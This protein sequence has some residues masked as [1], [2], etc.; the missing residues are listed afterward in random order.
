[1][2][3]TASGRPA[4]GL[5]RKWLIV[6]AGVLLMLLLTGGALFLSRLHWSS[7]LHT[8]PS[9][10]GSDRAASLQYQSVTGN[11]L[12]SGTIMLG[13][14]VETYAN[15]NYNQPFSEMGT[16]G[17]YDARVGVLE[18]PVTTNADSYQ[19]EVDN[20]VFNCQPQW[21][22]TL[23]KYFPIINI[24][25]DHLYDQGPAGLTETVNRLQ[26]AGFQTVG[27]Y[28]PHAD[29]DDCK[30]VILPVRLQK[31]NG[32]QVNGSLP[33][34][35]C[36][37]NY[38][39]IFSP[40]PAEIESIKQW[41]RIMPV[42]A[43][44]NG[45]PEYEHIAGPAQVSDAH[46]M[47][48]EGADF[49]IGNG[50]HWAQNT[51]VYKGKLI[52]Y[53]M[54]NFIFDQLDTDGRLALNVSVNMNLPYNDNVSKWL[55]VGGACKLNPAGCLGVV[56]AQKLKK[57]DPTFT[58]DA[59]ASYGGYLQV[60]HRANAQQQNYIDIRTNWAKTRRQLASQH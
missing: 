3:Y 36:S 20:L 17:K 53:S 45:G 5:H 23:K 4:R 7:F 21:L 14:A 30:P 43:L 2:K 10:S 40:A 55:Q 34:A 16:L 32:Q 51:E 25:S 18:C 39:I 24:S 58:F 33:V 56:D 37:F 28:N 47:I 42:V 19:N 6:G 44:M 11:Y 59:I 38:K 29:K 26:A 35:F 57:V 12:F 1:M 50:T 9:R 31:P 13:R 22:P 41:S 60:V 8:S 54:G 46:Q 52:V 49:V 27:N 15:G 48:D